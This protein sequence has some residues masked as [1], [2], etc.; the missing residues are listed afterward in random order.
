[1]SYFF[2][3]KKTP[4]EAE[5]RRAVAAA[6]P[7]DSRIDG[8]SFAIFPNDRSTGRVSISGEFS[9]EN[10]IYSR[11][12]P[13]QKLLS[14]L[15]S[16]RI[17]D[18]DLA[19]WWAQNSGAYPQ[20]RGSLGE[21]SRIY[22]R[23]ESIPFRGELP[24]MAVVD[25]VN[26]SNSGLEFRR[27]EGVVQPAFGYHAEPETVGEL[28]AAIV[29]WRDRREAEEQARREA[30][31]SERLA[32]EREAA[33]AAR[34]RA[35]EEAAA[36]A[37]AELAARRA[38]ARTDA[39]DVRSDCG[40]RYAQLANCRNVYFGTNEKYRIYSRPGFCPRADPGSAGEWKEIATNQYDFIPHQDGA[41]VTFFELALGETFSGTTCR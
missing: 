11:P 25:G 1:M 41:R 31:Q 10:D 4:S 23:G 37:E 35:V 3:A 36:Q 20:F 39:T 5:V 27:I 29:A 18:S 32:R 2:L 15:A 33:E 14:A 17:F 38:N 30:E 28:R 13:P 8:L 26:V 40:G 16:E 19:Q 6:L 24:Y 22:S 7:E 34:I 12:T 21:Y 9:F